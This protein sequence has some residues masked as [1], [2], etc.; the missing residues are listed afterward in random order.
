MTRNYAI[1]LAAGSGNRTQ[2]TIPKAFLK[3]NDIYMLEYSI[4]TF[5]E[6]K[7]IHHIILMVPKEYIEISQQLINEKAYSKVSWIIAGGDSRFQSSMKGVSMITTADANVLIHDAARPFVSKRIIEDCIGSLKHYDAVNVLSPVSDT[8]IK[9]ENN[10]VKDTVDRNTYRQ[11]QT[12]QGF[13][14][15][16]IKKAHQ[17]AIKENMQDMTDD[18]ALVLKYKTANYNWVTGSIRNFKITY[19]EDLEFAKSCS[20]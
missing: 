2:E 17:L 20:H 15:S 13:K 9:I 8:L 16:S 19:A 18:F 12:P 6:I 1:I 7:D 3:I 4:K 11:T 10:S 14:L 5:S